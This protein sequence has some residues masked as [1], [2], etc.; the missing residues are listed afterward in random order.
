MEATREIGKVSGQS[1]IQ[2]PGSGNNVD[3]LLDLLRE[4]QKGICPELQELSP[5]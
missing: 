3:E 1:V 2:T 4:L 5:W